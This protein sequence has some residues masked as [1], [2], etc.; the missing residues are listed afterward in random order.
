MLFLLQSNLLTIMFP[1]LSNFFP[2]F[3]FPSGFG[4]PLHSRPSRAIRCIA[5]RN[6]L[7]PDILLLPPR[8]H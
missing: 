7:R 6:P 8:E 5:E 2:Q 1:L 3:P 4:L